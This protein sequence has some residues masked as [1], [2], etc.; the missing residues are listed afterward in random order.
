MLTS[1]RTGPAQPP[2]VG[3]CTAGTGTGQSSSCKDPLEEEEAWLHD[4]IYQQDFALQTDWQVGRFG[5]DH[6]LLQSD[7]LYPADMETS[8]IGGEQ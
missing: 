5:F 8:C 3:C 2:N 4:Q 1:S 7:T 6:P